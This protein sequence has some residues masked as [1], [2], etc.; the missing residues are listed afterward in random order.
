MTVNVKT[1][2]LN[3][4]KTVE[5][6]NI[7]DITRQVEHCVI[8]S[9]VRNGLAIVHVSSPDLSISTMEYEPGSVSDLKTAIEK[10]MPNGHTNG[11]GKK[12]IR[13]FGSGGMGAAVSYIETNRKKAEEEANGR[14]SNIMHAIMGPSI[15]IPIRDNRIL[16]G[17]WQK[18]VLLDFDKRPGGKKRVILQIIGEFE[19]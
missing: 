14:K 5:G 7:T 18:V 11:I 2:E 4:D 12:R 16:V 9:H 15:T 8:E 19:N 13:G 10:L 3:Y 1:I 6:I 17:V